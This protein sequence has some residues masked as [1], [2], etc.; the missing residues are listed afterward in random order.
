M[1]KNSAVTHQ[2]QT[3]K[4]HLFFIAMRSGRIELPSFLLY[5]NIYF[6]DSL[7]KI[8]ARMLS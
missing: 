2:T 4:I 3:T 6:P 8:E 7:E 5:R 1:L